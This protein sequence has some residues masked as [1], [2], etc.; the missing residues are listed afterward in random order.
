[1]SEEIQHRGKRFDEPRRPTN[2]QIVEIQFNSHKSTKQRMQI[3]DSLQ[4]V[5]LSIV[6]CRFVVDCRLPIVDSLQIADCRFVVDGCI[7]ALLLPEKHD[8]LERIDVVDRMIHGTTSQCWFRVMALRSFVC[9]LDCSTSTTHWMA[10]EFTFVNQQSSL[11]QDSNQTNQYSYVRI[12]T[13][14]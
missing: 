2:R 14:L 1:M 10:P 11:C 4:I 9:I 5:A 7:V 12:N 8:D 3:V 13:A 6:D